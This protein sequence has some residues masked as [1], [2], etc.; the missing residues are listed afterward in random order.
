MTLTKKDK[1]YFNVAKEVSKLSD[2]PRIHIGCV[3]VYRHKIISSGYNALRGDPIQKRYNIYRFTDDT[4]ASVHA[5]VICLKPLIGREDINFK[6]VDLYV[7]RQYK[8]GELA[9]SRPCDSCFKL[10]RDLGIRN[11]YYTNSGGYSHEEILY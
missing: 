4:P 2:F 10:I 5:E 9:M 3:A 8:N 11:I 1:A 7:Y 6:Y